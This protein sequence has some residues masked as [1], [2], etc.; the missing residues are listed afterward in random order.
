MLIAV[1][2]IQKHGTRPRL[3]MPSSSD[4]EKIV[5]KNPAFLAWELSVPYLPSQPLEKCQ[6]ESTGGEAMAGPVCQVFLGGDRRIQL[7]S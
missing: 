4:L 3:G 5:L 1:W 2:E 6:L 7:R